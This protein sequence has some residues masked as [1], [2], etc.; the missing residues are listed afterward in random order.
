MKAG[1]R[2]IISLKLILPPITGKQNQTQNTE[3][4]ITI[5]G[6]IPITTGRQTREKHILNP[7]EQIHKGILLLHRGILT[8]VILHLQNLIVATKAIHLHQGVQVA[9]LILHHPG[10]QVA[11][12][13][14]HHPD[15]QVAVADQ[16]H[17]VAD[18]VHQVVAA[19][20]EEDN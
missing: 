12:A 10:L 11:E 14:A 7:Q 17:Q 1:I 19:E 6:R 9:K 20:A 16:D 3:A 2:Y 5:A 18:H 15:H 8:E 4:R 13:I